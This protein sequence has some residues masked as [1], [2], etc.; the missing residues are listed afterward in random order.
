MGRPRAAPHEPSSDLLSMDLL[1]GIIQSSGVGLQQ[2]LYCLILTIRRSLKLYIQLTD[3][4]V[5]QVY[6]PVA[7]HSAE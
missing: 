3:V 6:F 2:I 4:I 7:H 1:T 5:D